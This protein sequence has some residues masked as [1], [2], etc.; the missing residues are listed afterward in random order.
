MPQSTPERQDLMIKWFG[1]IDT[2]G[3]EDFLKS[4]GYILSRDWFWTKP[5]PSHTISDAEWECLKFLVEEWDYGG[6]LDQR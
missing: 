4:H 2:I 1:S 6:F 5:T 3:P